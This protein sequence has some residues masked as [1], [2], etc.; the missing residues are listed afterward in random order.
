MF[1][2]LSELKYKIPVNVLNSSG[3]LIS[4]LSRREILPD[5][6]G[7]LLTSSSFSKNHFIDIAIN[8]IGMTV[9]DKIEPNPSIENLDNITAKYRP[10]G[11]SYILAVGGGSVIDSAKALSLTLNI[12]DN[13]PLKK[14]FKE[15]ETSIWEESIPVFACPTTSGTGSEVTPYATIWDRYEKKKYSLNYDYIYPKY[16]ILD[17]D[18]TKTMPYN[19]TLYTALDAIS[20]ALESLW[21][22]NSNKATSEIA[23]KS[24]EIINYALP[25]VLNDPENIQ[26]RKLMQQASF[27]SGLAISKTQTAI[28]HSISYPLTAHHDIPHGLACSFTLPSILSFLMKK[29]EIQYF[30]DPCIY[31]LRDFLQTLDLKKEILKYTDESS[32]NILI[33]EMFTPERA[34][35]F[36]SKVGKSEVLNILESSLR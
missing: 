26:S 18:L 22:V 31:E 5:G 1:F 27:L 3:A 12:K 33:D 21:N 23:L 8:E 11:F 20:H 34:K 35:N 29:E 17:P 9:E 16:A 24:V 28:A 15:N 30:N 14:Y 6:N 32:I 2:E 36:I 10:F 25:S 4:A 7:L 13:D 19:L